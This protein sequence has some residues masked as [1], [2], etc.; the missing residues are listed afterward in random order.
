MKFFLKNIE[1]KG[2]QNK[3]IHCDE[4]KKK[5][6]IHGV[7]FV[8]WRSFKTNKR[9]ILFCRELM[10]RSRNL[11]QRKN[12]SLLEAGRHFNVKIGI[13]YFC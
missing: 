10:S 1:K 7:S 13:Y 11:N 6:R 9:V 2:G 3:Q 4:V 5:K 12:R 8:D